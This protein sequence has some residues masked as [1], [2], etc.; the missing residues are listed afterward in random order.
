MEETRMLSP[1]F[2]EFM[3]TLVLTLLGDGV[4]AGVLLKK[5]KGENSGWMV[6]TAGWAFAVMCGVFTAIACGSPGAHLNPAVTLGVAVRTGDFSSV[7]AFVAAQT[8]GA[9]VGAA[10]V[11]LHYL[12]HWKESPD[13]TAKL[14]V[15]CT[16]PAIRNFPA[17]LVSEIIGT[18]VLV[19]VVGAIFSKRVAAT[20]PAAGLGPFLVGSLVWG[21]GLSLG[22]TT[23]YAIN[24]AR[25]LGPRIA[26]A[27]LPIAGKGESDWGYAA[28]PVFGPLVGGAVAGLLAKYLSF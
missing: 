26:H 3:G 6:I 21:I 17:N 10:L 2:G 1:W 27:L 25:D 14:G 7:L 19:F 24:P 13:A 12:P 11:W 9:M 18:L 23:G 15:F 5:S 22:G 20:G 4:V 28:V 8:L 16:A